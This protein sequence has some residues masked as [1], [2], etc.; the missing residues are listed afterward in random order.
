MLLMGERERERERGR[1]REGGREYFKK[2]MNKKCHVLEFQITQGASFQDSQL[3][4]SKFNLWE[5]SANIFIE[6]SFELFGVPT[7]GGG[8]GGGDM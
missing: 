7:L 1:G 3:A 8:G 4:L 5:A 2:D 6:T